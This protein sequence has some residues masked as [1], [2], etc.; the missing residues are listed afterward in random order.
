MSLSLSLTES[1]HPTLRLKC[2]SCIVDLWG[3][4]S[5]VIALTRTSEGKLTSN[6]ILGRWPDILSTHTTLIGFGAFTRGG[7]LNNLVG[8]TTVAL[9]VFSRSGVSPAFGCIGEDVGW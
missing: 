4:T 9:E 6:C 3:R 2:R 8:P 1:S 5:V 7:Y